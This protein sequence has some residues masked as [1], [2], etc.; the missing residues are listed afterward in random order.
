MQV[1]RGH[2]YGCSCGQQVRRTAS[3]LGLKKPCHRPG[4]QWT[5]ALPS[6]CP[7]ASRAEPLHMPVCGVWL[8]GRAGNRLSASGGHAKT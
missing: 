4:L 7:H 8:V 5:L 6:V 1:H 2:P 3:T